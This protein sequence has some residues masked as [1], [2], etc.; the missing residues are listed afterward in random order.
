MCCTVQQKFRSSLQI[1][2]Q[3][4]LF[5]NDLDVLF[6]DILRDVLRFQLRK[7]TDRNKHRETKKVLRAAYATAASVANNYKLPLAA[8]SLKADRSSGRRKTPRCS[9]SPT[10]IL[11]DAFLSGE[12]NIELNMAFSKRLQRQSWLLWYRLDPPSEIVKWSVWIACIII[13]VI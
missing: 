10:Y 12:C 11:R 8:I 4:R 1:L 5:R 6:F 7:S 2:N 13:L 3:M 9:R